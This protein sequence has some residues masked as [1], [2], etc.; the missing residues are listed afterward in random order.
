MFVAA[1]PQYHQ[2]CILHI[3]TKPGLQVFNPINY[4]CSLMSKL[5]PP[6]L[7]DIQRLLS[8]VSAIHETAQAFGQGELATAALDICTYLSSSFD[9]DERN[10]C[11][12]MAPGAED[13]DAVKEQFAALPELLQQARSQSACAPHF[14]YMFH[15]LLT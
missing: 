13:L 14:R 2:C 5:Q 7:A 11:G 6:S 10:L 12:I 1:T 9:L 15:W 4:T 3:F 8:C